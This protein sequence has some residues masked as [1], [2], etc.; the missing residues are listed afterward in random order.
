M[1]QV[2][3][4]VTCLCPT[5]GRAHLLEE[6][7]HSFHLQDYPGTKEL[8]VLNDFSLQQ[9]QYEHPEVRVINAKCRFPTLGE[10]RN[11]AAELAKGEWLVTWGDDDIHLPHRLRRLV[12]VANGAGL[13]ILLEGWHYYY[14]GAHLRVNQDVTTGAHLISKDLYW[15]AGGIAA[16]NNGEDGDFNRRVRNAL[17][18]ATLP[19]AAGAPAFIYRWGG[20][21]RAHLSAMGAPGAEANDGYEAMERLAVAL[22]RD[23]R[24][25]AGEI[26]L[27]P[28]WSRSWDQLG[29]TALAEW[30]DTEEG[31]QAQAGRGRGI[32]WTGDL[33]HA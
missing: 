28:R 2:Y 27:S 30:M 29:Q 32:F 3:P 20:T 31:G 15:R 4:K 22:V 5:F 7:I 11:A 24:E 13:S 26:Y 9:F 14:D 1:S 23:D 33:V 25:P 10:K 21:D 16:M 8:I 18:L 6:A 12:E 19:F 17:G